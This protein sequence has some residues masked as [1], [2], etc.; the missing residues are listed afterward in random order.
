M[1][2]HVIAYTDILGIR[3]VKKERRI[4]RNIYKSCKITLFCLL[5]LI[6]EDLE[7]VATLGYVFIECTCLLHIPVQV[8]KREVI[9]GHCVSGRYKSKIFNELHELIYRES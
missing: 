6:N 7:I 4:C 3:Q 8:A 1:I 2:N 5:N 9:R